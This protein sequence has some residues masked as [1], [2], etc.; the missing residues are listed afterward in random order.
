MCEGDTCL[1]SAGWCIPLMCIPWH[2]MNVPRVWTCDV[3]IGSHPRSHKEGSSCPWMA[4]RAVFWESLPGGIL[5]IQQLQLGSCRE[6]AFP[7]AEGAVR[8]PSLARWAGSP[9]RLRTGPEGLTGSRRQP[10]VQGPHISPWGLSREEP[11]AAVLCEARPAVSTRVAAAGPC[12]G[13]KG[14]TSLRIWAPNLV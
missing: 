2:I 1:Q 14:V 10:L 13:A 3:H 9:I 5:P 8:V 4:L 6:G 12:F 7:K 11:P